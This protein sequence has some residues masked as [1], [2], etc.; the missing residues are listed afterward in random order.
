M[1]ARLVLFFQ[2]RRNALNNIIKI[3]RKNIVKKKEKKKKK[4][5]KKEKYAEQKSHRFR[6]CEKVPKPS[7]HL[8]LRGTL[9]GKSK[10]STFHEFDL[11]GERRKERWWC[12]VV[13]RGVGDERK[14]G[15][16]IVVDEK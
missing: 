9:Y 3:Q 10:H 15:G 11:Q 14:R 13:R 7:G 6:D 12:G 2:Y 8:A 5:K 16:W 4:K 1:W